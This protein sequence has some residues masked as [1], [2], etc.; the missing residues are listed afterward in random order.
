M[1]RAEYDKLIV[2][3]DTH[4]RLVQEAEAFRAMTLEPQILRF[5]AYL[6][7][8]D[9]EAEELIGQNHL[10]HL[11]RRGRVMTRPRPRDITPKKG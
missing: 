10:Y 3:L 6:G 1:N 9:I 4:Q 2:A 7:E 8:C 11:D 5:A